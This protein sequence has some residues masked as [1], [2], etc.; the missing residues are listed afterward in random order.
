MLK[1]IMKEQGFSDEQITNIEKAMKDGKVYLTGIENAE[2]V[3]E[4]LKTKYN[5]VKSMLDTAVKAVSDMKKGNSDNESLQKR[6][7]EMEEQMAKERLASAARIKN[8]AVDSAIGKALKGVDEGR[9][10]LLAK[11]FDRE[12]I[13]VDDNG[14][15]TGLDEQFKAIKEK[16]S[17]LFEAKPAGLKSAKPAGANSAGSGG[18]S[19]E[20]QINQAMGIK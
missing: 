5:D 18:L 12:K 16:Y 9:A 8:M 7:N 19:M 20:Q 15:V 10:E 14:T 11:A 2:T 4:N 13:N 1:K 3:C 17:D 6:I